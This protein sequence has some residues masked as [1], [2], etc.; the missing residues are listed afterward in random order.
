MK[1]VISN[2]LL[3]AQMFMLESLIFI[4]LKSLDN[5]LLFVVCSETYKRKYFKDIDKE[6]D[7]FAINCDKSINSSW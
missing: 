5:Y 1:N 2:K 4:T 6:I 7:K 3:K